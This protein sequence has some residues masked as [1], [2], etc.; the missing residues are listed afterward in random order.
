MIFGFN[1]DVRYGETVYHVQSEAR[2]GELLIQTQVFVRGQCIGKRAASYA[3]QAAQPGFSEEHIHELLKEQHRSV[4]GAVR[5]G[6]VETFLSARAVQD[7]G[8]QGLGLELLDHPAASSDGPFIMRFRVTY[9]GSPVAG[10]RLRAR[11][12]VTQETSVHCE[13]VTGTDGIAGLNMPV[14]V[15]VLSETAVLV[16]ATHRDLSASRKFQLRK[17]GN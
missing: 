1:T 6:R 14:E 15:A 13:A 2:A 12:A 11:W 10:A 16:Q 8:G 9:Q 7:A 5:D 4:L 3:D 17:T